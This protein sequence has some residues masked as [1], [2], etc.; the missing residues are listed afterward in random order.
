MPEAT[1][2]DEAP[3]ADAASS[4]SSGIGP[5]VPPPPKPKRPWIV[6]FYSSDVGKKWVMAVTG[7]MLLGFVLVHMIGNL[8]VFLGPDEINLYGE[9]L[10]DLGGHLVPR[11]SLLWILRIG[12][13]AAFGL[14]ILAAAQLTA[15]NRRARG[16]RGQAPRDY[17][18]ANFASRT[19]RW[20]GIIVAAFI[21]YH[22]LDL[23]WGVTNPDFVRGDVY[24]NM[25]ASFERVPV[26][27]VYIVA[28]ILL[29]IHIF[30]GAWSMFQSLGVNNPRFN[31]WRRYF[32]VGFASLI[33]VGNVSMPVA[34]QLGIIS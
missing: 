33:V 18:A 16:E 8:K 34:V 12:L 24:D 9:S 7:L 26:A 19:M 14:H 25:V 5:A 21:V 17:V 22:L 31:L 20:T 3:G 10:R 6:D 15:S 4:L 28:N 2:E 32:A 13:V 29:G 1:T 27:V 11:T 30:H 23:T